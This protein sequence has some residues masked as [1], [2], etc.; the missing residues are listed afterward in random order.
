MKQLLKNTANTLLAPFN[1]QLQRG[2]FQQQE[3]PQH[4]LPKCAERLAHMQSIGFKASSIVDAG[5][6]SGGWTA[7][8]NAIF[9]EAHILV[10][11]PNPHTQ[12]KIRQTI[13]PMGDRATLIQ[14]AVADQSGKM[15]FNIWGDPNEATSASLQSH[16][17][18]EAE[19][20]IEVD[21]ATIDDLIAEHGISPELIKLDLQGAE[22]KALHG[23]ATALKTTEVFVVEFGCLQAYVGRA[24]PHEIMSIFYD[25]NYCLYDIVDCHYRPYDG[26]LTGGDFFF[27]KNDSPLKAHVDYA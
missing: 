8:V 9:P 21:V 3:T 27:V 12:D 4:S 10:I 5:A 1:L 24:T 23:C 15:T 17:R 7:E 26:A 22:V 25:N 11:E 18:G 20:K 14:K 6:F 16:V 2:D 13:T 19:Y